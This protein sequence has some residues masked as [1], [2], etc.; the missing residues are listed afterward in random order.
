[1][2]HYGNKVHKPKGETLI[3]YTCSKKPTSKCTDTRGQG[4]N[5]LPEQRWQRGNVPCKMSKEATTEES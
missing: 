2:F 4:H 3:K 5:L 1:M